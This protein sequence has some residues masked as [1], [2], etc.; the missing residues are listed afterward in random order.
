[1]SEISG[2]SVE[3]GARAPLHWIALTP[4]L[5]SETGGEI[6][7]PST[8]EIIAPPETLGNTAVVIRSEITAPDWLTP[9]EY[10]AIIA[11][12]T[13]RQGNTLD[14]ARN[15]LHP[16]PVLATEAAAAI[17]HGIPEHWV[18]ARTGDPEHYHYVDA[19]DTPKFFAKVHGGKGEGEQ[20][21]LSGFSTAADVREALAGP[22]IQD[23]ARELGYSGISLVEPLA[24]VSEHYTGTGK[25]VVYPY[26]PG[27]STSTIEHPGHPHHA[28]L[29]KLVTLSYCL[30]SMLRSR[31]IEASG[32]STQQYIIEE[33][34]DGMQLHLVDAERF[35]RIQT[36]I[37]NPADQQKPAA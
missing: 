5:A 25:T 1:M 35:T 27:V 36:N 33:H 19:E 32:L 31:G 37:A 12:A 28:D 20:S 13:D 7:V 17:A 34:P 18:R 24:T 6:T 30:R 2:R 10:P 15:Y 4:S 21:V 14:T 22:G 11:Q 9:Q 16:E 8:D 23:I 26:Q 29:E 3:T